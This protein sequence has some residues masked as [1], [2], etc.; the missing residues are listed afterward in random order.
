[1]YQPYPTTG[2][3]VSSKASIP[4]AE[5]DRE[6]YSRVSVKEENVRFEQ[7]DD[8]EGEERYG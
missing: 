1:M 6:V 4:L 2:Y 3:P 7:S 8:E 5:R